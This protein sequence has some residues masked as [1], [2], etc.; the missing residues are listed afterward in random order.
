MALLIKCVVSSIAGYLLGSIPFALLAGKILAGKDLRKCGSGNLGSSNVF[1]EVGKVA[2]VAVFFLDCAKMVVPLLLMRLFDLPA[3]AQALCALFVIIG[4][5]W[6]IFTRFEGGRGLAVT[7]AG[8]AVL[9]PWETLAFFGMLAIG[10]FAHALALFAAFGYILWAA[11][12]FV[13]GEPAVA[14]AVGATVLAFVRRLQGSPQVAAPIGEVKRS[15]VIWE[16]LLFDREY[17]PP[18]M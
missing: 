16:R 10:F 12:A 9:L 11:L 15:K 1:R 2:G 4:H 17:R 18:E 5:N 8:G 6:P 7:L 14:F 3:L 13:R